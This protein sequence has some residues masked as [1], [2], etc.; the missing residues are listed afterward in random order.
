[1]RTI[2]CTGI[3]TFNAVHIIIPYKFDLQIQQASTRIPESQ[4]AALDRLILKSIWKDKG[5]RIIA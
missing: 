1:M 4:S 3:E 2:P 5:P